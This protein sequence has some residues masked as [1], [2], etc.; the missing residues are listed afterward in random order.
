[1]VNPRVF[2]DYAVVGEH[3][4]PLGRVV[5]ELFADVV[6]RTAENFRA[7]CTGSAGVN[8]I[9]IPLWY[10]GSPLHRVIAGFM[11]Q[12]GDFTDRNGKGGESIYGPS[13]DDENLSREIDSEGLL[14]MANKGKNTNSSQFFVTLRPCPHLK[15]KHVVLGRVVKG[16]E[17]IVAISK[18]PVDAKDRPLELIT[19]QH[20]GEL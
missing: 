16:F 19:I 7:L 18:M 10:K 12:G 14:C 9:G 20:C 3:V 15:G 8:S 4:Q 2:H 6:P 5:F 17:T 1:M 13:F 11:V